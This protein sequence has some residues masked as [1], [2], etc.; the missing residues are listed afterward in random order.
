MEEYERIL[1]DFSGPR[2]AIYRNFLKYEIGY[3][4][5]TAEQ[6]YNL[7]SWS[8]LLNSYFWR[9]LARVE[10]I[11][12]NRINDVLIDKIGEDWLLSD[13]AETLN[14][15]LG[16]K[17]DESVSSAIEK[18]KK[19]A[20]RVPNNGRIIA[21]LNM[22]F[23][24]NFTKIR[25]LHDKPDRLSNSIG[26]EYFIP[27]V[28][29]GYTY[30]NDN[31]DRN[32][33]RIYWLKDK[34]VKDHLT[35]KLIFLNILRNRIAHHEHIFKERNEFSKDLNDHFLVNLQRNYLHILQI[36]KWISPEQCNLYQR[37]HFH[38]YTNYL[39]SKE[40]FDYHVLGKREDTELSAFAETVMDSLDDS[41]KLRE[42]VLHVVDENNFPIGVFIPYFQ[43]PR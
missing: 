42:N 19:T 39:I 37:S 35:S 17:G 33:Q 10:T 25:F 28:F 26:W 21:E 22:G 5:A 6:F 7:Y 3:K 11:L 38:Y 15:S 20:G 43:S 14:I 4:D 30:P 31:H 40:G 13:K 41:N 32:Y 2:I 24:V 9:C 23:W 29:P 27:D 16:K 18:I 36:F 34:N 12:R 1:K 8:E